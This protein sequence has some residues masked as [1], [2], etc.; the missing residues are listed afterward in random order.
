MDHNPTN[1]WTRNLTPDGELL[2]L[3]VGEVL[4]DWVGEVLGLFDGDKEGA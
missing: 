3:I 2:G 4:G 1:P